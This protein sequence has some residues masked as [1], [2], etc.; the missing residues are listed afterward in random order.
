MKKML[1][2]ICIVLFA[3]NLL[4]AN[5]RNEAF[6][7]VQENVL[8]M[9]FQ[10][11]DDGNRSSRAISGPIYPFI[12]DTNIYSIAPQQPGCTITWSCS[13]N[14]IIIGGANTNVVTVV[15]TSIGAGWVSVEVVCGVIGYDE[16]LNVYVSGPAPDYDNY[17]TIGNMTIITPSTIRGTFTINAPHT[18]TVTAN[19][20]AFPDAEIIV[21]PGARLIINGAIIT[22]LCQL[23]WE[24]ITVYGNMTP[25]LVR[26]A[27]GIIAGGTLENAL[28]GINA[29][30]GGQIDATGAN[31]INNTT[32]IQ[33]DMNSVGSFE[34]SNFI[35][36][37][38]FFTYSGSKQPV[39]LILNDTRAEVVVAQCTFTTSYEAYT[40]IRAF[41]S[42][43]TVTENS[44]FSGF[45]YGIN[46]SDAGVL[47][48]IS[49]TGCVFSDNGYIGGASIRLNT[50][51]APRISDNHFLDNTI[52]LNISESTGYTIE[53]NTFRNDN[54]I[55]G[56]KGIV[57]SNS[58]PAENVIF[59]NNFYN[60]EV[61]IQALGKNSDQ[62]PAMPSATGLQFTCNYFEGTTPIIVTDILVGDGYN[63]ANHSVRPTQGSSVRATGNK[64]IIPCTREHI[65][66][67][68]S[69]PIRYYFYGVSSDEDPTCWITTL[70]VNP[71]LAANIANCPA[72]GKSEL[73]LYQYDELNSQYKYWLAQ[74]LDA[75][76]DS[77]E[78]HL[79]LDMVSDY[80]ATKDH[81]FNSIVMAVMNCEMKIFEKLG[82]YENLRYLFNYRN[83]YT[84]NL[85]L[86]ET[87]LAE[88]NYKEALITLAS[89]Y[90]LFKVTEEDIL[91]LQGLEIYIKWLQQLANEEKTIYMLSPKEVDE[92]VKYVETHQGRGV[93]FAKN[94]LCVLYDVCMDEKAP[95]Y[96]T[97][98]NQT[99]EKSP[100]Q[101][102]NKESLDKISVIPNPTT[103][104][105][106]ITN[107]ELRIDRIEVLD[108]TGRVVSSNH[109]ITSSS[110]P[111][112]DISNL[113]AGIYFVKIATDIGIVVK[114]VVKQ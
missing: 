19:I 83:N 32:A 24:G 10:S 82:Y 87:Y 81:L 108:I 54:M 38:S 51:Y 26:G 69:Y 27:V 39:Q 105:L 95:I 67:Y 3:C 68:S 93:V 85:N 41:N 97:P 44:Q 9:D 72:M 20:S 98:K 12:C 101:M 5:S 65:G 60:L 96:S 6:N 80:S 109:P 89:M 15:A 102:D 106:R 57:V 64:F 7:I 112:I 35:I 11:I 79:L 86:V 114:K 17:S 88:D 58:G 99:T 100:M 71:M 45:R 74:L 110:N 30:T 53:R 78:Y 111:Q 2:F 13:D 43:L 36:N 23:P 14:L 61:G 59:N 56:T 113:N 29:I 107:Y 46:A 91:E 62:P 63:P 25:P 33:I 34:N 16:T 84:D 77:E 22:S 48:R 1:F 28:L 55:S 18:V 103:G 90:Q 37:P 75:E 50:M 49:V 4:N 70:T 8:N 66:N 104:E 92:L 47:P 73:S 21:Q 42:F 94:I 31:F 76:Y 40:A 52:G